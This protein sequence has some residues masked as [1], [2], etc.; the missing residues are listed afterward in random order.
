MT[1]VVPALNEER[2]IGLTV[3][4]LIPIAR[5]TLDEFE[6]I[7]VDDGSTDRT[8]AIMDE[9]A[10]EAPEIRVEHHAKP[11]G[12]GAMFRDFILST[13]YAN[14]TMVAGDRANTTEGLQQLFESVGSADLVVGY[15]TRLR[16][17]LARQ[18]ISIGFRLFVSLQF[19]FRVRDWTGMFIWP[20]ERVRELVP[21]PT[22]NTYAVEILL[23]LLRRPMVVRNVPVPQNPEERGSSKVVCWRTFR[24][25]LSMARR[26]WRDKLHGRCWR[27]T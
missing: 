8:G 21:L 27:R 6:V 9:L 14:L 1:I 26:I 25:V 15:R 16:R 23:R 24:D 7:L 10:L 17:P 13:R 11:E 20:V 22:G 18:M 19:G 5:R 12:I 2:L 3:R 4:E